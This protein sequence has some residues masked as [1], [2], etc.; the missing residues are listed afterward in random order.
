[1]FISIVIIPF[2]GAILSGFL[3]RKIGITGSQ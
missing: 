1:M 3:G 2:L